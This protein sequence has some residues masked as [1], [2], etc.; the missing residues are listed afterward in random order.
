MSDFT[1]TSQNLFTHVRL[2]A[3]HVIVQ[4]ARKDAEVEGWLRAAAWARAGAGALVALFIMVLGLAGGGTPS[5]ATAATSEPAS[6]SAG[7]LPAQFTNVP[8]V[9]AAPIDTF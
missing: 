2:P 1:R 6:H 4:A 5:S 8:Y 7:Y 3:S 9:E